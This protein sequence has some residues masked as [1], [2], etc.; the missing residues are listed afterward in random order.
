MES[1]SKYHVT[2]PN[3]E[4]EENLINT[5]DRYEVDY[6]C[7][8]AG[9]TFAN[10]DGEFRQKIIENYFRKSANNPG[11]NISLTIE[12]DP[13]NEYDSNAIKVILDGK[14]IGFVPAELAK[15]I[16]PLVDEYSHLAF[17]RF[18][19]WNNGYTCQL[20]ICFANKTLITE[21]SCVSYDKDLPKSCYTK[22]A[23]KTKTE[24][25]RK[26]H[27]YYKGGGTKAAYES[28][29]PN[30]YA[31]Y[32]DKKYAPTSDRVLGCV[33]PG[34]IYSVYVLFLLDLLGIFPDKYSHDDIILLVPFAIGLIIAL[35]IEF[36][37]S[38]NIQKI[39]FGTAWR[40]L[41][42]TFITFYILELIFIYFS[43][44]S[45]F[46]I[47]LLSIAIGYSLAFMMTIKK[48]RKYHSLK[49]VWEKRSEWRDDIMH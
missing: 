47:I 9:I 29:S 40:G 23:W 5:Y 45:F 32:T 4:S 44:N 10:E 28:G 24:L 6:I 8:V 43:L 18:G 21:T 7:Q 17:G 33:W 2:F 37:C 38:T 20:T 30:G 39:I 16:K 15:V 27:T 35:L 25:E 26:A 48:I 34:I 12:P 22:E 14:Q 3:L 42:F 13:Y 46:A 49:E 19:Y 31:Y 41:I 11:N 36:R 1:G